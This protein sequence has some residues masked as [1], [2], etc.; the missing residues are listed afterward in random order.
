MMLQHDSPT[1]GCF[2][3][4]ARGDYRADSSATLIAIAFDDVSLPAVSTGDT[5]D[6]RL[7]SET[8]AA[9]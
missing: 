3:D 8:Q 6:K 9:N 1:L 5:R 4:R 7:S 2:L